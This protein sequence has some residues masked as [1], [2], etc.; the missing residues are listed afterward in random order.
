MNKDIWKNE[1][2]ER[3][4]LDSCRFAVTN[5]RIYPHM[6]VSYTMYYIPSI[7]ACAC[8]KSTYNAVPIYLGVSIKRSDSTDYR[9]DS[10]TFLQP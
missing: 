2:M 8:A 5:K 9:F 1:I 3:P 4:K 10:V 7:S 6:H